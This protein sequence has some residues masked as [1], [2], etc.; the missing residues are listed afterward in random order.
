MLC[1]GRKE[2]MATNGDYAII[3]LLPFLVC[4]CLMCWLINF[5]RFEVRRRYVE[6]NA[7]RR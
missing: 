4:V 6:E 1:P 7:R 2:V 5:L 3:S